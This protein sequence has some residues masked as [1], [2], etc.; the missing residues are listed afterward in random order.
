MAVSPTC[1][2]LPWFVC[3]TQLRRGTPTRQV[4]ATTN[5][6]QRLCNEFGVYKAS[7]AR[8]TVDLCNQHWHVA[9]RLYEAAAE[10]AKNENA[11]PAPCKMSA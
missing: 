10:P 6:T 1:G 3:M 2:D 9:Q 11:A 4:G 7:V 8:G 5:P